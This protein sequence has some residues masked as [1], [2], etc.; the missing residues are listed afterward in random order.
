LET[1]PTDVNPLPTKDAYTRVINQLNDQWRI[2]ASWNF[3]SFL[4]A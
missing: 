3:W 4:R 1:H 2:Y